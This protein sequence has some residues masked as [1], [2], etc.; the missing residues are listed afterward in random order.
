MKKLKP[1]IMPFLATLLLPSVIILQF[2]LIML[3]LYY[4][5]SLRWY[6][7][8]S[9]TI[10]LCLCGVISIITLIVLNTLTKKGL[11][12]LV[13]ISESLYKSLRGF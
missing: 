9:P 13:G 5:S 8:L 2:I 10:F 7:V 1:Y 12:E 3:K 6:L 4:I 11:A